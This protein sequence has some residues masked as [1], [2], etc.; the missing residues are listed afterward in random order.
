VI[1]DGHVLANHT[2]SHNYSTLYQSWDSFYAEIQQMEECVSSQTGYSL[3]KIVRFP[4]GSNNGDAEILN[5]I[6][7]NLSQL[8]YTYF[9]WNV[10][11]EDAI[12]SNITA[13]EILDNVMKYTDGKATALILLHTTSKTGATVEALPS[14]IEYLQK[15]GYTFHTL[16]EADA[17]TGIVFSNQ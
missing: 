16:D 8:G 11:G 9:D 4:G 17:P 15:E 12:K 2:Y 3:S 10:S 5:E 6:K 1:E 7:H 14:I 13:E